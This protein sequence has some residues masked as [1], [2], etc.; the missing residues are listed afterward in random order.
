MITDE[1]ERWQQVKQVLHSALE[2]DPGERATFL[3]EACAGDEPLR[4]EVE[5]LLSSYEQAGSLFEMPTGEVAAQVIADDHV[6][7]RV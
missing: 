6:K 3:A 7:L 4:G 5:A 2:R 1:P